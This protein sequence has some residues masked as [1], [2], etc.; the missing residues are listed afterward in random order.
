MA[1]TRVYRCRSQRRRRFCHSAIAVSPSFSH[2]R[3]CRIP[4]GSRTLGRCPGFLLRIHALRRGRSAGAS[5]TFRRRYYNS[6]V[7]YGLK[8][9]ITLI[10]RSRRSVL[11]VDGGIV[12][13]AN[14]P[15]II[16]APTQSWGHSAK[17][18]L[19]RGAI[20]QDKLREEGEWE[21]QQI[22]LGFI[23]NLDQLTITLHAE[24]IE[25]ADACSPVSL[26]WRVC[27]S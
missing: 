2:D 9:P 6:H 20:N 16:F 4:R 19:G 1:T 23:F 3:G 18:V 5:R 26:I 14:A 17:G 24:K 8:P 13:E 7:K 15:S 25:G 10:R 22:L 11:Y 21:V 27:N 12:V